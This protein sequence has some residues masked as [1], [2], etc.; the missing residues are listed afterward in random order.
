VSSALTSI[1]FKILKG[2]EI[3]PYVNELARLR[4]EIFKEFPYIYDGDFE[5]EKK[6]LKVYEQSPRS[7][8]VL[9]MLGEQFVGASTA[10]PLSDENDYVKDP[11]LKNGIPIE[12]LFY[13]GE[14]ILQKKFR[15]L[16]I[17]KQFFK[18][19]E[20]HALSFSDYD[21]TCFCSVQRPD[22]H[23]QRPSDYL[24]LDKFWSGLGYEKNE[25]MISSFSWRDIGDKTETEKPMAYWFKNWK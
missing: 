9:A 21:T 7:L 19:R 2:A 22:D 18:Y 10:L 20:H 11:F 16:G 4:I 15:G 13:F 17:G 23:P 25:N 1:Q 12:K 3:S 14:S 8:L 6:Y 5:Y 24:P